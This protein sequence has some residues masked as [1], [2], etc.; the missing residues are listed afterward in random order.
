MADPLSVIASGIAITQFSGVL[1]KAV[2]Q[3]INTWKTGDSN[4]RELYSWAINYF[5]MTTFL[6]S[7]TQVEKLK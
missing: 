5:K 3:Q 7:I 2:I 1:I 4:I 6:Y